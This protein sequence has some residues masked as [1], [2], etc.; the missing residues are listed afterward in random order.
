VNIQADDIIDRD[1][2]AQT[3]RL[4]RPHVGRTSIV[5]VD[6]ADFGL[7]A[8]RLSFEL[9]LLQHAGSFK[10]RGAFANLLTRE[11]PRAGAV[12]ASGGNHGAAV[13]YASMRLGISA[14]IFVPRSHHLRRF[15]ESATI[16]PNWSSQ[17]T[18]MPMLSR[19]VKP[20]QS[21]Q[22]RS[23]STPSTSAKHFW[24]REPS[25][26]RRRSRDP[27]STRFSSLPAAAG[28]SAVLLQWYGGKVR[29]VGVEP[30]AAQRYRWRSRKEDQS[31][32]RLVASQRLLSHPAA[33]ARSCTPSPSGM[34]TA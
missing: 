4:I 8:T 9:E 16:G 27:I 3:E 34:W 21:N 13:A 20:G 12:A 14:K 24:A 22:E 7:A 6:A 25:G 28:L 29:V 11:I 18:A 19:Q 10:T 23:R 17:V 31:M 5:E 26:W 33:S 1:Y 15:R 30:K 32:H 2:I